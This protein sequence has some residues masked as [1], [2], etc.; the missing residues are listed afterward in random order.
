MPGRAPALLLCLAALG[1]GGGGGS[2]DPPPEPATT[3]TLAPTTTAARVPVLTAEAIPGIEVAAVHDPLRKIGFAREAPKA[4]PGVVTTTSKRGDA[5]VSTYGKGP[6]DVVKVV[7]E[8]DRAAAPTVLVAV[9]GVVVAGAD[10]RKAETW[11][12]AELAKGSISPTQP[13]TAQATFGR[14]PF[15]LLVAKAT[16]TLSVGR[17]TTK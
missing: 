13:R 6:A 5:T 4:T 16:A 10:A 14:Q 8:A 3:T 17:L 12:K 1:C 15:E 7:A 2:P 9:A 11:V